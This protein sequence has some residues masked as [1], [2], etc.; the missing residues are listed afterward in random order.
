VEIGADFEG[1][2]AFE[3]EESGDVFKNADDFVFVH[4]V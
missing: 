4:R 2:L 1:I 3:F